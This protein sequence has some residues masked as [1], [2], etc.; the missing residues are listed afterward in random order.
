M[1]RGGH[2]VPPPIHPVEVFTLYLLEL[3]LQTSIFLHLWHLEALIS[4]N[5]SINPQH[6][7]VSKFF[8]VL[9]LSKKN[10][11]ITYKHEFFSHG[12]DVLTL[13]PMF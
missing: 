13:K 6:F 10:S 9:K 5:W 7:I 11:I 3:R 1:V 12:H 2:N 4:Q 8:Q